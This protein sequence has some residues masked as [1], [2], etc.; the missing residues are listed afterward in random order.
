M[1]DLHPSAKHDNS[2]SDVWVYEQLTEAQ[3]RTYDIETASL[4]YIPIFPDIYFERAR[5]KH[6]D[7]SLALAE[8]AE[9]YIRPAFDYIRATYP[10]W[11]R[12]GGR[13]HFTTLSHSLGRCAY[14]A[15][16][17]KEEYGDMFFIQHLGA[18][19]LYN[20]DSQVQHALGIS[21]EPA[22]QEQN[23]FACYKPGW[24][25]LLPPVIPKEVREAE[26]KAIRGKKMNERA[27][28]SLYRFDPTWS[29]DPTSYHT[30]VP[31]MLSN[32]HEKGK[33]QNAD[34]HVN[35]LVGT[36]SDMQKAAVCVTP[37][38]SGQ[39]NPLFWMA[40]T[41]G[42]IPVSFLNAEDQPFGSYIDYSSF[43]VNVM[44]YE[45]NSTQAYI[46]QILQDKFELRRMQYNLHKAQ[47]A[48]SWKE[49]SGLSSVLSKELSER[50]RKLARWSIEKAQNSQT[51][52]RRLDP[53]W[54]QCW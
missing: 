19:T 46:D 22:E 6:G 38:V 27:L 3:F 49:Q 44:P 16:L 23:K 48:F 47:D 26:S 31:A 18:L 30:N 50:G 5:S 53:D 41:A 33:L 51:K 43:S 29:S 14:L 21:E 17:Q 1:L 54:V 39:R 10:S 12:Y 25:V 2:R 45:A 20:G 36:F 34:W 35:D 32:L 7:V 24:D 42:C 15:H 9:Q 37:S 40:V 52:C 13:G 28:K 4:F 8:T 11:K